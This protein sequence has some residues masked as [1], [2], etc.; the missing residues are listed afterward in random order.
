MAAVPP[1]FA[2]VLVVATVSWA[3]SLVLLATLKIR[4]DQ[5]ASA[6]AQR[7]DEMYELLAAGRFAQLAE[8]LLHG[9][10]DDIRALHS[11]LVEHPGDRDRWAAGL[12]SEPLMD[13]VMVSVI[14]T[15]EA[16]L[17]GDDHGTHRICGELIRFLS[18]A[19]D[20]RD[21]VRI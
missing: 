16:A 2:G 9:D 4:G 7:A 20:A 14:D 10:A 11:L 6:R 19:A 12:V 17:A 5:A 13:T 15:C 3:A 8:A 21:N 1:V 18:T